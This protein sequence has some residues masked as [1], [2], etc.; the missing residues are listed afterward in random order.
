MAQVVF[1]TV[2][3]LFVPDCRQSYASERLDARLMAD[4]RAA[5][6]ARLDGF[7][8]RVPHVPARGLQDIFREIERSG[9]P[10]LMN[11]QAMQEA[12][13]LLANAETVHGPLLQH[14]KLEMP[15]GTWRDI[16]I[17]DPMAYLCH[18]FDTCRPWGCLL[19]RKHAE[20]PNS[21]EHPWSLIL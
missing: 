6:L 20:R 3:T 8:R 12:R 11:R 21:V 10:E 17:L 9:L 15:D 18:T 16:L 14:L 19:L 1:A 7:R 4:D 2:L 13:S 5:K